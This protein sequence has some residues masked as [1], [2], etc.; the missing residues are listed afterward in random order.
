MRNEKRKENQTYVGRYAWEFQK[1]VPAD[2][3][4]PAKGMQGLWEWNGGDSL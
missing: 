3:P 4:V 2:S 1:M